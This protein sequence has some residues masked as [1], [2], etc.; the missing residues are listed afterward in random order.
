VLPCTS[1]A[2]SAGT[3]TNTTSQVQK[4]NPA[5]KSLTGYSN[6][7]V[8]QCLIDTVNE[9]AKQSLSPGKQGFPVTAAREDDRFFTEYWN[10]NA[11]FNRISDSL[12]RLHS[13]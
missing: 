12:K 8:F 7:E 4:L 10:T 1:F 13:T 11:L 6:L 2:E 3:Y 9:N 5:I